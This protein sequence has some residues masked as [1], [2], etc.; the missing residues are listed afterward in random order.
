MDYYKLRLYCIVYP[1][2][3]LRMAD[4]V[5]N[6]IEKTVFYNDEEKKL[7]KI[8]KKISDV[9]PLWKLQYV[10]LQYEVIRFWR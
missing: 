7:S 3:Q 9:P 8:I 4:F 2:K 6:S 5:I 10:V 1:W